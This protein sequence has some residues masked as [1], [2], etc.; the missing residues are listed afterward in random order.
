MYIL[1]RI[2]SVTVVYCGIILKILKKFYFI[3]LSGGESLPGKNGG[4]LFLCII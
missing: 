4:E 2:F 1:F 3:E